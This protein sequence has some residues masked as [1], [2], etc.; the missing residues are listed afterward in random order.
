MLHDIV[1]G[2]FAIKSIFA[3][4]S[5][6]LTFLLALLRVSLM[7]EICDK[8]YRGYPSYS[9][10]LHIVSFE[11]FGKF[12]SYSCFFSVLMTVHIVFFEIFGNFCDLIVHIVATIWRVT[13]VRALAAGKKVGVR[14]LLV[15]SE[16]QNPRNGRNENEMLISR[17]MLKFFWKSWKFQ[18]IECQNSW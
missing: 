5:N 3:T 1:C 4:Q 10:Y 2:S 18:L 16:S 11:I 6:W 13:S 14:P 15:V 8:P 9:C 17:K 7:F 12:S